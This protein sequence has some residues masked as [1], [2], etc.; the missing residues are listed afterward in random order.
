MPISTACPMMSSDSFLQSCIF[1]TVPLKVAREG[2]KVKMKALLLS[3]LLL[4]PVL[5]VVRAAAAPEEYIYC[6]FGL[7][8]DL[9]S[10][11]SEGDICFQRP[12]GG[13]H[14]N[15]RYIVRMWGPQ[16]DFTITV[17]DNMRV[18]EPQFASTKILGGFVKEPK[19]QDPATNTFTTPPD[20]DA[21]CLSFDIN[22]FNLD[23]K[24][25]THLVAS[26]SGPG[27]VNN[28]AITVVDQDCENCQLLTTK[29]YPSDAGTSMSGY[30]TTSG[31]NAKI[32][33]HADN[34]QGWC[35]FPVLGMQP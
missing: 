34:I 31:H 12:S 35:N 5:N 21:Y 22:N 3:V 1:S 25:G 26:P 9:N 32:P 19:G 8:N 20:G 16:E 33:R 23:T 17:V 15:R 4:A 2:N 10:L 30:C 18:L 7:D 6:Q 28:I 11:I 14:H 27:N 13:A 29:L 24:S